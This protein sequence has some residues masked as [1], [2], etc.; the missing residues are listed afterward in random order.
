MVSAA[1]ENVKTF[2]VGYAVYGLTFGSQAAAEYVLI[3]PKWIHSIARKP[4]SM[5][6]A[7]AACFTTAAHTIVQTLL[8]A[9]SEIEGG[10]RGKV[11]LVPTGLSGT[12]SLA[13][14]L[15][16]AVFAV[17]KLITPSQPAR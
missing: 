3:T 10:L 2:V 14:Q 15:L 11:V 16:K 4:A 5:S 6:F 7:D 12:G 17:G 1:G 13:L 9:D 8:R